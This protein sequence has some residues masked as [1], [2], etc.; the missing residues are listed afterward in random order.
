ME[1]TKKVPEGTLENRFSIIEERLDKIE[2]WI[3]NPTFKI[4][5][6]S[7]EESRKKL[8]AA[9]IIRDFDALDFASF[10]LHLP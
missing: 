10:E 9:G 7:I 6:E 4:T 3:K 1:E 2:K 5:P 8:V